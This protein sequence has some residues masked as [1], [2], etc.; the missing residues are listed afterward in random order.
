[1][2]WFWTVTTTTMPTEAW[3]LLEPLDESVTVLPL[4][5]MD[6]PAR[7]TPCRP[8][9]LVDDDTFASAVVRAFGE[10]RLPAVK[11]VAAG[12]ATLLTPSALMIFWA[13]VR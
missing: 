10:N 7:P 8:V 1:M 12:T 3:K 6:T 11:K 4:L 13:C 2:P 5:L 9:S